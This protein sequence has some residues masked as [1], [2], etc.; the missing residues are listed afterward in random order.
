MSY[1][2]N[3]PVPAS[4]TVDATASI[5]SGLVGFWP[6]TDGTS[7]NA[8][9]LSTG[10]N[11]G[12]LVSTAAWVSSTKGSA[13]ELD[14]TGEYVDTNLSGSYDIRSQEL[15]ISG[16][17]KC[18]TETH[19]QRFVS[20]R[21]GTTGAG[22]EYPLD[23]WTVATTGKCRVAAYDG[24]SSINA[25][26]TTTI[27]D[28][29]WHHIC[30][31][32]DAT[33][34]YIY[35]DGVLENQV[36][37]SGLSSSSAGANDFYIGQT[38]AATDSTRQ[39]LGEIQNVRIYNRALTATEVAE[40]YSVP[41]TGTD[42]VA[43]NLTPDTPIAMGVDPNHSLSS[44]LVGYWPLSE[45][46]GTVAKDLTGTADLTS[47]N[48]NWG[49]S[50]IG[51]V[52][53]FP[54][55]STASFIASSYV[56]V[57]GAGELSVS[58]WFKTTSGGAGNI[59]TWG[60]SA[61]GQVF[62]LNVEGGVLWSRN[63][64]GNTVSGGSGLN[65]GEWHVVTWTK[66][67]NG[68]TSDIKMFVDG[69]QLSVTAGGSTTLSF[70][71][72]SP[73]EI[74]DRGYSSSKSFDGE[75]QNVRA[76][77]RVLSATEVEALYNEPW[78]GV[79]TAKSAP[80]Q[81]LTVDTADSINTGLQGFWPL[82]D[83]DTTAV[84]LSGN[85][86]DGTESGG[87]TWSADDKGLSASFD[88]VD[89]RFVLSNGLSRNQ[90]A[91]TI[92]AWVKPD[93]VSTNTM[94]YYESN[95]TGTQFTRINLVVNSGSVQTGGRDDD[96]DSFTTFAQSNTGI[97]ATNIW[98]H[99]VA[100]VDPT[101]GG[102]KVYLD[103]EN[104]TNTSNN[105]GDGFPDTDPLYYA[106]GSH[107]SN[108]YTFDGNI[109]NV[110]VYNR[111]LSAAEVSRLYQDPWA[112]TDRAIEPSPTAKDLDT[113]SSLT[114]NLVGWW[115]LTE[116]GP[117]DTLAYDISG[118]DYHGVANGGVQRQFTDTVRAAN[119][120]GVDDRFDL[121]TLG[122]YEAH[123]NPLTVSM[124]C[125]LR[126]DSLQQYWFNKADS[127]AMFFA[128]TNV[129]GSLEF[130]I[131]DLTVVNATGKMYSG[132]ATNILNRWAH[133]VF[134]SSGTDY[135]LASNLDVYLDGVV[136]TATSS[137][138][139]DGYTS[140][141]SSVGMLTL[142]GRYYDNNRNM[143]AMFQNVRVYSRALSAAEVQT[144]YDDP[145]VGLATDSL[146]YAYYSA[147]FLQRLG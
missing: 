58:A 79:V 84:D 86:N 9:D 118:N 127:D 138:N 137:T 19:T 124:W 141:E 113:S 146:V 143:D 130:K 64:S 69:K 15:S 14:A 74:G 103:G 120:D 83:N 68:T 51:T 40:L 5:N 95:N 43:Q 140:G 22:S 11:D 24:T 139:G 110:R 102:C 18:G 26:S 23:L 55:S 65:D 35:V 7:T 144:L 93:V 121:S 135:T 91:M 145:W 39:L 29:N 134:V 50:S 3:P 92:S 56:P 32:A 67:G 75:I 104:V 97:V 48:P 34:L 21:G 112:G 116:Y 132:L 119:L 37:I 20:A 129:N 30:G 88:G 60:T 106:I 133:L 4:I 28:D 125:Y 98:Q 8:T 66:P 101:G 115:P 2:N 77:N 17:V 36:A 6:L 87:V 80:P 10:G 123:S 128:W 105:T 111:A 46:S 109:Q 89:D 25:D 54:N 72:S 108:S 41:W 52:G 117:Q 49:E 94:V 126:D 99:L 78:A 53:V 44:G 1:P 114:T 136:Q 71:T 107:S 45:G 33:N 12:T 76:Y 142:G 57:S 70:G 13:V 85:G 147:A 63:H 96:G 38:Q 61:A 62:E 42:Y 27:G 31:V 81:Y 90:T 47:T 82:S 100:V 16:W 59:V 73:L 122:D 131:R